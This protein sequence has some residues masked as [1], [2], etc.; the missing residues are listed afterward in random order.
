[1]VKVQKDFSLAYHFSDQDERYLWE[2]ESSFPDSTIMDR[3][4]CARIFNQSISSA[5]PLIFDPYRQFESYLRA[6]TIQEEVN[7]A[8]GKQAIPIRLQG[9]VVIA[10]PKQYALYHGLLV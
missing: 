7:K 3:T 10:T 4:L 8:D 1:M 2:Q 5:W 9:R 6:L